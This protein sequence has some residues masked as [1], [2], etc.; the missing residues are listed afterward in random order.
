MDNLGN[1]I[2]KVAFLGG[3]QAGCIGLLSVLAADCEVVSIVAYG[4]KINELSRALNI[5]TFSSIKDKGFV[6]ILGES[7][8]L[9]CVHGREIVPLE[10]LKIPILGCVN[11]HPCL[12]KY[13][14]ANPI[15]H[16]LKDGNTKA[17]V[18]VHYMSEEIDA[19]EVIVES[20]MDVSGLNTEIEVYNEL[21]PTYTLVILEALDMIREKSE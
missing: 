12:Y 11:V 17:S 4:E 19:G 8:L 5:P 14:G 13:K 9:I 16:L 21:Y 1:D 18:G 7:D 20:Y 10:I 3:Q 15:K 6:D 2:M